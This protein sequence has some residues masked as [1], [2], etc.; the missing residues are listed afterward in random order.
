MRY[1]RFSETVISFDE[2]AR[3]T[4]LDYSISL[5]QLKVR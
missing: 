1:M 5:D 4:I 3:N 2:K